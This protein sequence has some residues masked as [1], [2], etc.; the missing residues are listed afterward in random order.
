MPV[1][2][3]ST[4]PEPAVSAGGTATPLLSYESQVQTPLADSSLTD[5]L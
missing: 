1:P 2:D 5:M 4:T 3:P